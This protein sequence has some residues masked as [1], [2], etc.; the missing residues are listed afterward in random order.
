MSLQKKIDVFK[1]VYSRARSN[2]YPVIR[3]FWYFLKYAKF[4]KYSPTEIFMT[5]LLDPTI[6]KEDSIG[7]ISAESF[8]E[9]EKSV[10]PR[11]HLHLT[12]DKV[13]F[14]DFCVENDLPVPE[15]I[16]SIDPREGSF[17]KKDEPISS[18]QD[19]VNGLAK[20]P[21]D[22]ICKPIEGAHGVQVTNLHYVDGK[23]CLVDHPDT[24]LDQFVTSIFAEKN[25]GYIIQKKLYSHQHVAEFTD[26]PMLQTMRIETYL[27]DN[28]Q[29]QILGRRIKFPDKGSIVDNFVY[30]TSQNRSCIVNENGVVFQTY[31]NCPQKKCLVRYDYLLNAEGEKE[32]LQMPFWPEAMSMVLRAQALFAPLKTIG[33]DVAIT[34]DGPILIEGNSYWDPYIRLDGLMADCIKRLGV[35]TEQVFGINRYKNPNNS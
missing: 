21:F 19:L 3:S 2:N 20:Y 13:K 1:E 16:A 26:N 7:M 5:D 30:G 32:L 27:D 15:T 14:H 29:P 18:G 23:H 35:P 28:N 4:G 11:S 10:N 17:W 34:D 9:Y 33:W 12:E 24:T 31:T 6:T 25:G 8:L 22:L